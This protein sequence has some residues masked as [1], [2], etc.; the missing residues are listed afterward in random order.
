MF[1][2]LLVLAIVAA[3]C[4]GIAIT[5]ALTARVKIAWIGVSVLGV[6]LLWLCRYGERRVD[7][8]ETN[9]LIW[10]RGALGE[11][12]VGAELER[13]PDDYAIF[14]DLNVLGSGNL[15]HIVIGPT[16]LFA[17]ETKNWTGTVVRNGSG[18]LRS[19]GRDSSS[20]HVRN[21]FKRAMKVRD[22]I[23]AVTQ[24]DGMRMRCIMV[25]PKARINARFGTTGHVHCVPLNAL[26]DYIDNPKFSKRF[27][28]TTISSLIQAFQNL[29]GDQ[30]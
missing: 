16:G 29:I 28:P 6:F 9:R 4:E 13:L 17:I 7:K 30:V 2:T 27:N 26:R 22:R 5:L 3:F 15:D 20:P 23:A 10:R 11:Y 21:F 18:E 24:I 12:E 25:F 8:H 19:N 1:S 14:N